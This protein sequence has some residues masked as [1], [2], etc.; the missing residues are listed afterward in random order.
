MRPPREGRRMRRGTFALICAAVMALGSSVLAQELARP[1]AP[2]RDAT[3]QRASTGT[4]VIR[5][6]VL[7]G[8]TGR[9]L[10]RAQITLRGG[11]G[12]QPRT[13]STGLDGRYELRDL[14]AG[15]FTL[16]VKRSSYL[17]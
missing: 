12:G 5:G 4:A 6:R 1:S 13:T 2:P 7:A 17:T 11:F 14:P 3:Q 9:P 15:R 10:R 16:E 8:D